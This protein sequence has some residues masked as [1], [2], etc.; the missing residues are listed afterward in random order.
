MSF[1]IT[2]PANSATTQTIDFTQQSGVVGCG[3]RTY[4][5]SPSYSF[6][7][8]IGNAATSNMKGNSLSL[9]TVN[10]ADAVPGTYSVALTVTLTKY[11]TITVTKNFTITISCV[12]VSMSFNQASPIN[13]TLIV[14]INT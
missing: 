8:F 2:S 3:P 1:V 12:V 7:T 13:M 14:G 11:P 10:P 4:T 9:S 6:L 5:L